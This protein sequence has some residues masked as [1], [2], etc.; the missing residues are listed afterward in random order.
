M[1]EK[2]PFY[3]AGEPCQPND[4]LEVLDKF[5]SQPLARVAL[6]DGAAMEQAISAAALAQPEMARLSSD[7]RANILTHCV[8][9]F[10]RRREDLAQILCR[11]VGKP[12]TVARAEVQRLIET[13]KMAAGEAIRWC[14][15]M[16]NLEI[17][18]RSRAY[19]GV[20]RFFP[21]G[22]CSLIT[23][24]NFPLNLAAHKIAPAI[25]SGCAFLASM[26]GCMMM[27]LGLNIRINAG[28]NTK[29]VSAETAIHSA[30]NNPISA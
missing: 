6:A 4:N 12:I 3:L 14:G 9:E 13:F 28:I 16:I 30:I 25:A 26:G 8:D 29:A 19:T 18:P 15:E 5:S 24:F 17:S 1:I 20:S 21:I 11:E 27:N 7:I 22:P 23:P 2:Y 10:E